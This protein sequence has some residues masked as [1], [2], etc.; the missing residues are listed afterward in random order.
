MTG[1]R[2]LVDIEAL[3]GL[4]P[5][6]IARASEL[7]A[8]GLSSRT[9]YARCGP[10]GAWQ[11]IAPGIVLLSNAPP[12]RSQLIA[13]ALRHA[14]SG[15]IVTG[16]D[17]L[18]RHGMNT[19]A[20]LREVHVL[21]PHSRQVRSVEHV[22]IER[23]VKMPSPLL[24]KGFPIAPLPRAAMDAARRLQSTD[25]ARA[26]IGQVVQRGR[27]S[28]VQLRLEL[29][30]G[31][32]RGTALPRRVLGEVS[33]GIRSV[34]EAWARKLVLRS[35]LPLPQWNC[36]VRT[37]D[38]ELLGIID[39]WWDD[40]GLAWEIDSYQFHLSPASY[41]ETL[42]RGSRL[43]AAGIIVVHTLPGRLR[44]EPAVV[45]DELRRAHQ[46]AAVRPRPPVVSGEIAGVS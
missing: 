8:L 30:T 45:L 17:A 43:T 20:G 35:G 22:L 18:S 29:E 42:R 38:G 3:T 9:I 44:D 6:R 36:P 11:R 4:F 14:G 27:V 1:N 32:S 12:T 33:D 26:L 15:A 41:A 23:T 24:C 7:I 37:P 10:G 13:S 46:H 21:V 2:T 5:H 34:A 31:S 25:A 28:P 39:A 16:W 40:V 19:P